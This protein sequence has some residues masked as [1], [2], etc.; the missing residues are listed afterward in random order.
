MKRDQSIEFELPDDFVI[1][2]D[3]DDADARAGAG[4]TLPQDLFPLGVPG[5]LPGHASSAAASGPRPDEHEATR[6]MAADG[7]DTLP[8][9][10]APH[11]GSVSAA[12]AP[13]PAQP[14]IAPPRSNSRL[15]QD[16]PQPKRVLVV[17]D[18]LTM[19]LYMRSR[20]MLRG[21]VQ[22]LEAASGEEALQLV[23]AQRF[24]AVLMDVDMGGQ[25]GYETCRAV[26]SHVRREGGK[27]PRIYMI[28]S[29]S[30]VIDKMR[31]KMAGADAFLSKPP[32]PAEL[33]EL[34][35]QL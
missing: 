5:G 24:D 25:N 3:H 32:H 21:H 30:S 26:R 11:A 1:G 13:A 6:P 22:L 31:A 35:A 20:L 15:P 18:D 34:L 14:I 12:S 28:T 2:T 8:P 19:R 29:R 9:D 27:Q 7:G 10:L 23:Q 16:G 33:S 17:D 4:S